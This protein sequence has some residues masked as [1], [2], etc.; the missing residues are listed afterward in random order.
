MSHWFKRVILSIAM[1]GSLGAAPVAAQAPERL[2]VLIGF[3]RPPGA[4]QEGLVRAFGGSIK[5]RYHLV[6]AIAANIPE[7]AVAGLLRSQ[8]VLRVEL[9]G[10]FQAVDAELDAAWGVKRIG[11]G[12]VHDGGNKGSGVKVAVIDSGI[13]YTHPDLSANYL[14]GYDF[15]ND[16][17]DPMDDYS[18]GTHVAGTIG[19]A[20]NNLGVV[21][22][23][24][25]AFL[26]GLKVLNSNGS[27]SFSDIIAALQWAVDNGI[28]VTN[29]SYGSSVNP[30]STVQAAFDNSYA[31]G[32]L[33]IAAGGNSGNPKGKR[34]NVIYPAQWESVVAVAATG[35]TDLRASFSSTGPANELAAPGV[36]ILSTMPGGG[37]GTKSGTSM[38]S[39]HAAGTA[40]LI[41]AAGYVTSA[42]DVRQ[43]LQETADDLGDPGRDNHYGYGLVDADEA[44]SDPGI[45]DSPPSVMITSPSGIKPVSG[46]AAPVAADASDDFG[47]ATVE[48]LVDG[49]SIGWGTLSS[50]DETNGSWAM[51]GGWDSEA[52]C[53]GSHTLSARAADTPDGQTGSDP[54][55]IDVQ[56]VPDP[57]EGLGSGF[58][59]VEDPIGCDFHGGRSG[60]KH[61]NIVLTVVDELD[62]PVANASVSVNLTYPGGQL[63]SPT[64]TTAGDGTA[65]FPV[66]NAA[67][68]TYMISVT[69]VD[70]A[71][72]D[73]NGIAV[74]GNT[75]AK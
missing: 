25:E 60:N 9:D 22:V 47:V 65:V 42:G 61:L 19:A 75:C 40:A 48:F 5:Y 26:Y 27:G 36:G 21:G 38:A 3:D 16:D 31:A 67:G 71:P 62:S 28:Q 44:A 33:H 59:S 50:G 45:G 15:V 20:D 14:G 12:T 46:T 74:A 8:R 37:Y 29:N 51:S 32:V 6:P 52:V 34:N 13:D 7:T 64:A 2:D 53:N 66:K 69:N 18:H 30:G 10:Q 73:W 43:R 23:A 63:S 55:Q 39:P 68:G 35:S 72:L 54:M 41:I 17:N 4:A 1:L 56:N 11:S 70:A 58:V 57:C 49:R 24:P